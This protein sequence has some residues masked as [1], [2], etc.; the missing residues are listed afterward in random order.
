LEK[1]AF[2]IRECL[3]TIEAMVPTRSARTDTPKR[4]RRLA[5]V[6]DAV[7]HR[8]PTGGHSCDHLGCPALV[9]IEVINGERM[10]ACIDVPERIFHV[11][12]VDN[13]EHRPEDFF[14]QYRH[15]IPNVTYERG[16]KYAGSG[17]AVFPGR[18]DF[19]YLRSAPS[20]IFH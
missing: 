8:N 10:R 14:V 12:T 15:I 4:E 7:V 3:K 20:R 19:D 11:A 1:H 13:R 2:L 9:F 16:R 5:C 6:E 18:I 17:V